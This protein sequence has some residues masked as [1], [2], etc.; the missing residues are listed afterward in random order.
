MDNRIKHFRD[1]RK[2]TQSDLA[3]ELGV[4][5]QTVSRM[6]NAHTRIM[7]KHETRLSEIFGVDP[8]D[9]YVAS[10][11]G[12]ADDTVLVPVLSRISAGKF[13]NQDGVR[14]ADIERHIKVSHLPR[15]D[16]FALEVDG[17][18]MDRLAPPGSVVIVNRAE[19]DPMDGKHYIFSLD[20][21]AATFKQFRKEPEPMLVPQS[22][23]PNHYAVPVG[24]RE[25]YVF[26]RVRRVITDL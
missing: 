11:A 17:D 24:E 22:F 14:E 12:E 9:I 23:N 7:P 13:R 8:S 18:S 15:G 6:E 10:E 3:D 16:W 26:G 1:S 20:D 2:W 21:G 25:L 4:S 19:H 5:W